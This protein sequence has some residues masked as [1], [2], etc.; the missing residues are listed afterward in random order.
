MRDT[1]AY[2]SHRLGEIAD[3]IVDIDNALRWGF[4][5]ELGPFETWDAIGVAAT[6]ERMK[7]EGV[8]PA[9]WVDE[10]LAGGNESFY[11]AS[12]DGRALLGPTH[13]GLR[14]AGRDRSRSSSCPSS[15]ATSKK[16]VFSEQGRLAGR[17]RRR[18]RLRRVPLRAAAEA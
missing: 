13:Q 16:V 11:L 2:T 10:M 17:P 4:N 7:A 12:A 3:T 5:W 14:Q 18:H 15:S 8:E 9:P 1:L 6:V